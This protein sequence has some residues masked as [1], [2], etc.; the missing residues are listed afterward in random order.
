MS[1][2]IKVNPVELATFLAKCEL[3][4]MY[5]RGV[6]SYPYIDSD[7]DDTPSTYTPYAQEVFDHQYDWYYGVVKQHTILINL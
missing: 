5:H 7:D 3:D 1:Q 6:I 4:I 2:T